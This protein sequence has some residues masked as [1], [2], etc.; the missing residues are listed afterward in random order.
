MKACMSVWFSRI[1]QSRTLANFN[2][3]HLNL[4]LQ[5]D[6]SEVLNLLPIELTLL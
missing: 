6:Q 4:V 5:D 1:D 2:R 3:I